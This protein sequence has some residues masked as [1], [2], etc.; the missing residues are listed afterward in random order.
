MAFQLLI[1]LA[2][3]TFIG[4][5]L[6][7]RLQTS[8]PYFTALMALLSLFAGFYL[9]LKDLLFGEDRPDRDQ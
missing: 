1:P 5:K 6:D 2:I 8:R 4:Y 7:Q 3:G 9:S